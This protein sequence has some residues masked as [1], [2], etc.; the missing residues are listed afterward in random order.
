MDLTSKALG[1]TPAA[2]PRAPVQP[3]DRDAANR[4]VQ[5]DAA[6]PLDPLELLIPLQPLWRRR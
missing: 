5:L 2:G 4:L 1:N 3:G 6:P